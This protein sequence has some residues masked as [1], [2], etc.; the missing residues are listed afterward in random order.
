MRPLGPFDDVCPCVKDEAMSTN[1]ILRVL[2][3][4]SFIIDPVSRIRVP[5]GFLLCFSAIGF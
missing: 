5:G 3:R 2:S 4:Q 1:S